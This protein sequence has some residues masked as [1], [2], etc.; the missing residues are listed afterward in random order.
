M[1]VLGYSTEGF[2][3]TKII[4]LSQLLMLLLHVG[5]WGG[6]LLVPDIQM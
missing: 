3:R 6:L 5:P 1:T 4:V 2:V